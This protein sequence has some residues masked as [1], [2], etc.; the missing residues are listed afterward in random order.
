MTS[1]PAFSDDPVV[2]EG[3]S[4]CFHGLTERLFDAP[5]PLL[6]RVFRG[7]RDPGIEE[8]TEDEDEVV[9]D[10]DEE[11]ME[12]GAADETWALRDVSFRLGRGETIGLVGGAGSGKTTLLR[13]LT[14]SILASEGRAYV[15]GVV[16]PLI[17]VS[18]QFMQRTFSPRQNVALT[19][20]L[21]G[22]RKRQA[23]AKIGDVAELLGVPEQVMRKNS[24][25]ST[26]LLAAASSLALGT[27]V[28]FL[29]DPFAFGDREFHERYADAIEN[30]VRAGTTVV[31][32][33][34]DRDLLSALCSGALWLQGGR[35]V[36]QGSI[37]EILRRS[38]AAVRAERAAGPAVPEGTRG[39][40][41][42]AAIATVA[43]TCTAAGALEVTVQ[44][45]LARPLSVQLGVGL[46]G[47]SGTKLWYEQPDAVACA[48][49]G[50]HAFVLRAA[51]SRDTYSGRVEV[52]LMSDAE[53]SV[54]GRLRAFALA[55]AADAAP[56]EDELPG[57]WQPGEGVWETLA[58]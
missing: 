34:R 3:L 57:V 24:T 50:L 49:S 9:D 16:P 6:T 10:D 46:E 8:E 39:F 1:E 12:V 4:K 52:R 55:P 22:L 13:L 17:Q 40:D 5:T 51:L 23:L 25:A 27:D 41:Q 35:L 32:E 14:G 26:P 15:R 19:G 31:L 21:A 11:A 20:A 33:S 18:A 28:V 2:V 45:E 43:A 53:E 29:D 7:R 36:A 47:E 30:R 44:L 54:I 38:D 42:R 58:P 56:A 37:E 48:Q